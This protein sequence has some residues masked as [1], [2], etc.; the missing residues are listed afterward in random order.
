MAKSWN[1]RRSKLQERRIAKDVGGRVQVGSGSS[2]RAKSDVRDLGKLRIEAKFTSKDTYALRL[3]DLLKIRK[4]ALLGGL[5]IW[6][7]QVE[8]VSGSKQKYAVLDYFTFCELNVGRNS[9]L[10]GEYDV[11]QGKQ[12]SMELGHLRE[13]AGQGRE[14]LLQVEF[15]GSNDRVMNIAIT[16]WEQFLAMYEAR[17]T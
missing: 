3:K 4:E 2:W 1:Q 12:Y 11:T 15:V 9:Y 5:E 16:S 14:W 13:I 10:H 7:M 6:A 8:F 17:H